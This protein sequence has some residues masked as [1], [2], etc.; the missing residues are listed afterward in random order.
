MAGRFEFE[1]SSFH[2]HF[3]QRAQSHVNERGKTRRA[4][5]AHLDLLD[6][7]DWWRALMSAQLARLGVRMKAFR[8]LERLYRRGGMYQRE[9]S[10]TFLC[11][12]QSMVKEIRYLE[13]KGWVRRVRGR[14]EPL[15]PPVS[16]RRARALILKRVPG[17]GT[18]E[19]RADF[20]GKPE[21]AG[22][23]VGRKIVLVV[24]TEEGLRM[25]ER[26]L[27]VYVKRIKCEMRAL[28]GRE[29][30]NLCRLLRKLRRGDAVR[31]IRELHRKDVGAWEIDSGFV[32]VA[33]GLMETGERVGI[34]RTVAKRKKQGILAAGIL[35]D[36]VIASK[37]E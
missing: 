30:L 15:D 24:L 4:Y 37:R 7:A 3:G 1:M 2:K 32:D 31:W 34:G 14:L 10:R 5:A 13:R 22:N 26:V 11:S 19:E 9:L 20:W 35:G 29:Q 8:V 6:T 36:E 23:S 33:G 17:S 12:K 25:M 27:P 16:R 28:D 18:W 21:R